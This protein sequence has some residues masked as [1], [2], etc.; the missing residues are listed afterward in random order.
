MEAM[1]RFLCVRGASGLFEQPADGVVH[2]ALVIK[3]EDLLTEAVEVE[4]DADLPEGTEM[5]KEGDAGGGGGGSG[6]GGGVPPGG[7]IGGAS[8]GT[9]HYTTLGVSRIAT[10]QEIQRAFRALSLRLHPDRPEGNDAAFQQLQQANDVL[11]DADRK[12]AYD[13]TLPPL[14]RATLE[15]ALVIAEEQEAAIQA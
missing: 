6:G 5:T 9:T 12:K 11:S 1:T 4:G 2:L 13:L 3:P 8:A 14:D 15:R 10:P 7:T